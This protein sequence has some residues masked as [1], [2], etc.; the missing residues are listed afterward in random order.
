MVTPSLESALH[1]ITELQAHLSVPEAAL[2]GLVA[3]GSITIPGVRLLTRHANVMAHEGAHVLAGSALG[4]RVQGV[5]IRRN[6]N[7][8]TRLAGAGWGGSVLA[9]TVG[10]LGPSAFGLAAA[11]L[12]HDG[13]IVAVL[14][15][16][17]LAL[18]ILLFL[19]RNAF[20]LATAVL[21]GL[22][23]YLVAY[24]APVGAQVVVAYGVAWLMLLSGVRVVLAHGRNAGDA[25]I[26]HGLTRIPR[27]VWS[28]LWL[29]GTLAALVVGGSLLL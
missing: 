18:V 2:V 8:E 19:V 1:R 13:R 3:L 5:Q 11:A 10:Y 23:L 6:G 14:W 9:A 4:R 25:A 29:A 12:I 22:A 28:G 24:Y 21:S 26:L 27:G 7:G 16:S 20:G 15:L 17:L